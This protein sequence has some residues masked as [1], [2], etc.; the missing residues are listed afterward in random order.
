M[1]QSVNG[2]GRVERGERGREVNGFVTLETWGGDVRAALKGF[3]GGGLGPKSGQIFPLVNFVFSHDPMMVTLV[4]RR[5]GAP[6]PKIIKHKPG[7][8]FG[9]HTYTTTSEKSVSGENPNLLKRP[10]IGARLTAFGL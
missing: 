10:E 1:K 2:H 3:L 8:R 7:G 4:L 6:L 9:G 5:G